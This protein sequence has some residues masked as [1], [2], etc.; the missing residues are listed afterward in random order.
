MAAGQK[1]ATGAWEGGGDGDAPPSRSGFSEEGDEMSQAFGTGLPQGG[2]VEEAVQPWSPEFNGVG[3]AE[4]VAAVAPDAELLLHAGL[5][6]VV[7]MDGGG[8]RGASPMAFQALDTLFP[9]DEGGGC[10]LPP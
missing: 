7:G 3:G 8:L 9:L 4:F 1:G 6:G 5:L 2:Q 10:H